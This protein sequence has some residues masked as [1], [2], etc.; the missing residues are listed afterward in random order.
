[1][2]LV[3]A[4]YSWVTRVHSK[5][6]GYWTLVSGWLALEVFHE[7]WALSFP[8]LDLGHAFASSPL[9]IQWYEYTGHRGGTFWILIGNLTLFHAV[10]KSR[11]LEINGINGEFNF[12]FKNL[13]SSLKSYVTLMGLWLIPIM[14]SLFLYFNFSE[15]EMLERLGTVVQPNVDPYYEKFEKSDQQQA[16]EWAQIIKSYLKSNINDSNDL[17]LEFSPNV[18]VFPETFL[19]EGLQ[20]SHANVFKPIHELDS[21]IQSYP[22]TS[23]LVGAMTYELFT[24]A[25]RTNTSRK[26]SSHGKNYYDLYNSAFVLSFNKPMRFYHKSKL[27]VG[28]EYMPFGSLLSKILGDFTIDMGGSAGSLGTQDYRDV[29]TLIDTSIK[30]APIICWEQDYG[31]YVR[32]YAKQGANVFAIITNDGWWGNTLGHLTHMQ[33][34]RV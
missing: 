32:E 21:I 23:L 29:F 31:N 11:V 34:S 19:H 20:E 12:S 2:S 17:A 30:L 16:R 27:V 10:I 8:W 13:K 9:M 28:V 24:N 3:F 5:R 22:K 4:C 1:M 6:I 7:S 25:D 18:I 15:D 14:F 26:I 33:Y